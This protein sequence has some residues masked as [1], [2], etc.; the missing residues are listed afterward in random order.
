MRSGQRSVLNDV[1]N[2]AAEHQASQ[3]T[4]ARPAVRSLISGLLL[5][6]RTTPDLR[7]LAA[8]AGALP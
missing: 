3:E 4:H 2:L 7:A 6:G 8:R 5:S 1:H